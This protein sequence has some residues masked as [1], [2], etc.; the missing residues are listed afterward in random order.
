MAKL[1]VTQVKSTIG[2]TK[3]QKLTMQALGLT[4]IGS[5]KEVEANA[6]MEGMIRK[7]GH[8]LKVENI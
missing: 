6:A 4:K 2:K 3:N 1:K 7:V 8:L 5:S